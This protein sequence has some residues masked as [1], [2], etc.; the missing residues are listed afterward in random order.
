MDDDK[1]ST[2]ET[3]PPVGNRRQPA[4]P[5]RI[6]RGPDTPSLETEAL[7]DPQQTQQIDAIRVKRQ[8]A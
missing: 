6:V 7:R 2:A 5:N 1:V 8:L 3:P 4:L